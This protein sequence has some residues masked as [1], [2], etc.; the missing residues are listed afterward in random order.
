ML[1]VGQHYGM[2][3]PT[4]DHVPQIQQL[5][6]EAIVVSSFHPEDPRACMDLASVASTCWLSYDSSATTGGCVLRQV[7]GRC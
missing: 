7:R 1:N 2:R 4:M 3:P 6:V 5:Q